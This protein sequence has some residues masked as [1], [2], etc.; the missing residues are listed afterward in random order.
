MTLADDTRVNLTGERHFQ[1]G[2][3][4][5]MGGLVVSIVVFDRRFG[6]PY[7]C[8]MVDWIKCRVRGKGRGASILCSLEGRVE[9]N[10]FVRWEDSG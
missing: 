2:G 8:S 5:S 7:L 4:C 9:F 3:L 6:R 1:S 10:C